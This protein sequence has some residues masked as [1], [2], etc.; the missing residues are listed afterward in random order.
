MKLIV[1]IIAA[2]VVAAAPVAAQ[3]TPESAVPNPTAAA[4]EQAEVAAA[5]GLTL[6]E[7]VR[8]ALEANPGSARSRS[9]VELAE[10]R[11]RLARSSILPQIYADGRYTR[12]D[13]EV[14]VDFGDGNEVSIMPA[15]DW[16]TSVTLSQPVF[17]GGR[18]LKAIR[19]ARLAVTHSEEGLRQTDERVLLDVASG[20]LGVLGADSLIEVEQRNLELARQLREQ[21]QNFFEAGEV[22]RVDVLRAESSIR[23]AE[24][25]LVGARQAR[26]NAASLLRLSMGAEVPVD[27]LSPDL[28]F[29]AVPSEEELLRVAEAQRPEVAQARIGAEVANLEVRKQRGAYLPTVRAEASYVQQA[30]AFPS[31]A[32][33]AL[34]FNVNVP[35]FTSGEIPS[36]VATAREQEKQAQLVLDEA[37][38]LVRED[39]R[40]AVVALRAAQTELALA[41]EQLEAA[42]A[43]YQQIFE[44]YRAQEA[45]S[46]DVQSAEASLAASRRAVVTGSLDQTLAELRVWHAAG[47]LK[48]VLLEEVR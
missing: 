2:G 13:R 46:L 40:R 37:R 8:I 45:T 17:A 42:E 11:V 16:S 44:L 5:D 14:S 43:E 36:R 26:E 31:D 25:R 32:Y 39:V 1:A 47:A 6:G 38:H 48:S 23:G 33:G 15:D 3:S 27:R 9:D 35:I 4:E 29:P 19:Q 7:A 34:T 18:E 10:E 24:R 12:N 30:S 28:G 21:S 41:R 22:T 20:Y